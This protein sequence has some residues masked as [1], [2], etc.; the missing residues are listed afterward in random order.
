MLTVVWWRN[1][2]NGYG[3]TQIG[4]TG[5]LVRPEKQGNDG[6]GPIVTITGLTPIPGY[7][8]RSVLCEDRLYVRAAAVEDEFVTQPVYSYS[9]KYVANNRG[10]VFCYGPPSYPFY[11]E[12]VVLAFLRPDN[13]ANPQ[14]NERERTDYR[15]TFVDSNLDENQRQALL[16]AL[17][18]QID[19]D[20]DPRT[21]AVVYV[22]ELLTPPTLSTT[23]NFGN[24]ANAPVTTTVCAQVSSPDG[25]QVRR[26]R[27]RWSTFPPLPPPLQTAQRYRSPIVSPSSMPSML[28]PRRLVPTR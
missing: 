16:D 20:G 18:A 28:P 8:A 6:K 3:V 2:Y 17:L 12:G 25:M 4:A 11:P 9:V 1:P 23:S 19:F 21:E 26:L 10:I 24:S 27:Y 7:W 13:P 14:Q 22:Q 15:E 5:G